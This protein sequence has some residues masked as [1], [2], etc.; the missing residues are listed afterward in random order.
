M[1]TI[2]SQHKQAVVDRKRFYVFSKF[3]TILFQ[4][5]AHVHKYY[6]QEGLTMKKRKL[7]GERQ[8]TEKLS[9]FKHLLLPFEISYYTIITTTRIPPMIMPV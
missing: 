6:V 5:K 7:A 2:Y 3:I 1:L 8:A 9:F 4:P